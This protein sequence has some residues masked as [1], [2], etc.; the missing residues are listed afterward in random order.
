[1]ARP[2]RSLI[3]LAVTLVSWSAMLRGQPMELNPII[4]EEGLGVATQTARQ[5]LAGD[6]RLV[7]LGAVGN[8]EFDNDGMT[9]ALRFTLDGGTSS[10]WAYVFYSPSLNIRATIAAVDIPGIGLQGMPVESPVP[11]PQIFTAALNTGLP[12]SGSPAILPRLRSDSTYTRYM[13]ELPGAWPQSVAY[14]DPAPIDSL[15]LGS[16]FPLDGPLWEVVFAGGGDSAMTC[17]VAAASGRVRALR[18]S[19]VASAPDDAPRHARY[20]M[21]VSSSSSTGVLRLKIVPEEA[22][23]T[24]WDAEVSLYDINGMRVL[25]PFRCA[26]GGEE[27]ELDLTALPR[28]RYYCRA[29]GEGWSGVVGVAR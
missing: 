21:T 3:A 24:K 18:G 29:V 8:D 2:I 15:R 10:A 16:D 23:G 5:T 12:F 22:G 27:V 17:Y 25:G 6:A 1:M 11:V 9:I 13:A 14:H 20:G 26:I 28:G 7:F 4:A 19:A